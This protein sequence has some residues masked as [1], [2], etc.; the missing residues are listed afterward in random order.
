[1]VLSEEEISSLLAA[2][3]GGAAEDGEDAIEYLAAMI[4]DE[5][6][7]NDD[8]LEMM[9]SMLGQLELDDVV[10]VGAR[11]LAAARG[12]GARGG[13]LDLD[14]GPVLLKA[15]VSMGEMGGKYDKAAASV[16][17]MDDSSINASFVPEADFIAGQYRDLWGQ[18]YAEADAVIFVIDC[19]DKIRVCIAKNE[20]DN[21]LA[22]EDLAQKRTPILFF[23]NKMDIAGCLNTGE[24]SDALDLHRIKDKPWHIAHS[25]GLTG[26]GIPEGVAWLTDK[27]LEAHR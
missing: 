12:D 4:A 7:E 22:H 11:V 16:V 23:A 15:A 6:N 21:M 10:A 3:L 25:N 5:D 8:C 19:K 2:E 17:Q 9:E 1:M 24:C 27:L 14:A 20:L 13:E 26:D 18:K